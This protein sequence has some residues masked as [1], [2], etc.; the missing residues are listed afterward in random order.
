[1]TI[2][3]LEKILVTVQRVVGKVSANGRQVTG[4]NVY[5]CRQSLATDRQSIGNELRDE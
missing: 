3:L 5:A 1:M 2:V 4:K